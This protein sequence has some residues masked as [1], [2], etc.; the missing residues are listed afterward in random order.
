MT[1]PRATNSPDWT[2]AIP[3]I[4]ANTRRERARAML[5]NAFPRRKGRLVFTRSADEVGD[6]LRTSLVDAVIVDIAASPEESLRA[7]AL[8]G[9]HPT[10]AFFGVTSLRAGDT[11]ALADSAQRDF[12]GVLVEGVDDTVARTLVMRATFSS[13]FARALAHPPSSLKLDAP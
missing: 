10:V 5:R 12:A 6:A 4:V 8:A 13:R 7:A 1:A 11:P 2:G 3:L 9:D